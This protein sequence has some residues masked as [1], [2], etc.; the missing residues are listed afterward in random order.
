MKPQTKRKEEK[1]AQHS[2]GRSSLSQTL[3]LQ[4]HRPLPHEGLL[5]PH[6]QP[7]LSQLPCKRDK[8]PPTNSDRGT[9][10]RTRSPRPA[11]G[12][13]LLPWL[14]QKAAAGPR[15]PPGENK[16][17]PRRSGNSTRG[18]R[19][20]PRLPLHPLAEETQLL[21]VQHGRVLLAEFHE[22]PQLVHFPQVHGCPRASS[23]SPQ[24]LAPRRR[25]AQLL[26]PLRLRGLLL[27]LLLPPSESGARVPSLLC[28]R[29]RPRRHARRGATPRAPTP[30]PCQASL[31]LPSRPPFL[32][33][34]ARPRPDPPLSP[35]DGPPLLLLLPSRPSARGNRIF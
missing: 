7:P 4:Q 2:R 9:T 33:P 20:S 12:T 28:S 1:V 16:R 3:T 34:E 21:R 19:R 15:S 29:A 25:P 18:G 24:S 11:P 26:Q 8:R 6:L 27:V 32:T 31:A 22:G 17:E 13:Q 5:P 30:P 10:P 23:S 14:P 35:S